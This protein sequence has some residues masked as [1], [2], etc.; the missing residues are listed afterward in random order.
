MN[1]ETTQTTDFFTIYTYYGD[2]ITD[3]TDKS[4]NQT[5]KMNPITIGVVNVGSSSPQVA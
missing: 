5:V 4:Q 1:S 3:P 2:T